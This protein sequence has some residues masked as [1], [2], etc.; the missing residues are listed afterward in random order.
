MSLITEAS[1]P[2]YLGC[3]VQALLGRDSAVR[4]LAVRKMPVPQVRARSLATNLGS[5]RLAIVNPV[6]K[7]LIP[8]L[9]FCQ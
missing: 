1:E 4:L 6:A 3:P 7:F 5:V 2:D 9:L 8:K